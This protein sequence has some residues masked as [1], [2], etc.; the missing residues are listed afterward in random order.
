VQRLAEAV[1]A[2]LDPLDLQ[3]E[4]K[5]LE[6][7]GPLWQLKVGCLRYCRFVHGHHDFEDAA[8]LPA[9]RRADPSLGPVVERIDE[10]HR[11]IS[12]RLDEVVAAASELT[13]AD[14]ADA[15]RQVVDALN[16]LAEDLLDHLAY[17]E[18]SIGPTLRRMRHL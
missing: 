7:T 5:H 8:W 9:L 10:E 12:D 14:T 3:H 2:G 16:A 6:T 15:R 11:R 4:L 13:D 17:E 18:L 1:L